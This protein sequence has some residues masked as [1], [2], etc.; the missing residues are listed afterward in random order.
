[1]LA[2]DS[3]A[4]RGELTGLTWEDIDFKESTIKINKTTQYVK[5]YGIFEKVQKQTL[6]ID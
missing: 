6:A 2:L 4:R 3:G 1:M 5:E